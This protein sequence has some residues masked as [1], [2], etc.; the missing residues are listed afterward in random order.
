MHNKGQ[1]W[2]LSFGDM[3]TLILGFFIT[4]LS[5]RTY[6]PQQIKEIGRQQQ[7]QNGTSLAKDKESPQL[8]FAFT[9]KDYQQN[10]AEEVSGVAELIN[11]RIKTV[12]YKVTGA[13]IET[14]DD[15]TEGLEGQS[16][17]NAM[18][19]SLALHRQVIDAGIAPELVKVRS[20]GPWCSVLRKLPADEQLVARVTLTLEDK[21]I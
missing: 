4:I 12:T 10:A 3:L 8:T 17:F 21:K 6:D 1:N 20:T 9:E 15:R 7:I 19:R 2:M 5:F 16:W 18:G 11:Q 14:C 13:S